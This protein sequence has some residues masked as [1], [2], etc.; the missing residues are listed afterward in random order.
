VRADVLFLFVGDGQVREECER[1]ARE[2]ALANVRFLPFQPRAELAEVQAS[3]DVSLVTLARGRGGTSV[4]SKVLGYMAAARPVLASVDAGCDTARTIESAGCGVV[5]PPGDAA[6]LAATLEAM[7]A[8]EPGRRRMGEAGRRAFER[9]FGAE[10]ALRRYAEM[11][12]EVGARGERGSAGAEARP[13]R[14]AT[15]G[16]A[17]ADR[18]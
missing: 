18:P 17:G 11:L 5:V 12:E 14:P 3:A 8:D 4:P 13:G 9:D 1:A 15:R 2:A 7:L 6:A 16:V 10:A